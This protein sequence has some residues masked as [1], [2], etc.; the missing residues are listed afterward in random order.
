M[1]GIAWSFC[2]FLFLYLL[3]SPEKASSAVVESLEVCS[4]R[5]IPSLFPFMVLTNFICLTHMSDL[6]S[7][8]CGR[9]FSA[10][11]GLPQKGVS[12]FI[13]G[14]VCGFPIGAVSVRNL[15][16]NGDISSSEAAKLTA[17][18]NNAGIAFCIGSVGTLFNDTMVGIKLWLVQ[19]ISA[20]IIAIASKKGYNAN[21]LASGGEKY[22]HISSRGILTAFA[23]SVANAALSMLKICAFAVFFG[24]FVK[25]IVSLLPQFVSA[26]AAAICELTIAVRLSSEFGRA[27]LP[28]CAFA[29]GFSGMSVHS[30]V[31]SVLSDSNISL[32]RYFVSKL[33]QGIVSALI[34][35][36]FC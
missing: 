9:V 31:A 12:A 2:I 29:L 35:V 28:I 4:L 8:I 19:F 6:L 17:V 15:Y 5:L 18:S 30:Q 11:T 13:L 14:S 36:I 25:T 16:K 26:F 7:L 3:R 22:K 10:L 33:L 27:G 24:V 21:I 1:L 20:V 32:R 23:E 34:A